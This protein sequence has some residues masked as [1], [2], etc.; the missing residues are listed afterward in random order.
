MKAI[1]ELRPYLAVILLQLGSAGSAIIAKAALNHGM[2]HYTF[3]VYRNIV[4]AVV[5]A[6]LAFFL[7]RK[8]RPRMTWSVA[9]KIVL[10]A[11]LEPVID[12]NLYYG[13]MSYTTATFAAAMCNMIPALTFLLAWMARMEAVDVRKRH[14]Q[15]KIVG[16]IFAFAGAMIMTLVKGP[17]VRLPWTHKA[18]HVISRDHDHSQLKG[19]FMVAA[20]CLCC[21]S[22]YILQA[23]TLKSYPAALSLTGLI[24]AAGSLLGAA[25]TL[26]VERRN[27][28]V[29]SIQ[30][31]N[32]LLAYLYS[33]LVQS[34]VAYYVAGM[35]IK[36]KGPVFVTS[37]NPLSMVIVAIL[38]SFAFAEEMN[39][40]KLTGAMVIVVGLYLVIWGKAK[41]EHITNRNNNK[42]IIINN[43]NNNN[44]NNSDDKEDGDSVQQPKSGE[45]MMMTMVVITTNQEQDQDQQHTDKQEHHHHSDNKTFPPV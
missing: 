17:A 18:L 31:D 23:I 3:S 34:G 7:E 38:S 12:Q 39:I 11:L 29:W 30:W 45:E 5:V 16:T 27:L 20:G 13:G 33:G 26:V 19:A 21:S 42:D 36:G 32:K 15:A 9:C 41:D 2:S 40:G 37:F 4:A 44:N 28:S 22:F 24:C 14:S 6:P 43:N 10:L 1:K 8:I 25:V 35:V